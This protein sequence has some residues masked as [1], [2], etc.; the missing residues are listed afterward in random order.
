MMDNHEYL[1]HS[2]QCSW[3]EEKVIDRIELE[4]EY[5]RNENK[6]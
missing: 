6:E 5:S 3:C 2:E 4:I 1:I